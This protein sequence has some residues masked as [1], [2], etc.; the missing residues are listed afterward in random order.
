MVRMVP[1]RSTRAG[2]FVGPRVRLNASERRTQQAEQIVVTI[3]LAQ[4]RNGRASKVGIGCRPSVQPG[5]A[6]VGICLPLGELGAPAVSKAREAHIRTRRR[7][8]SALSHA[9]ERCNAQRRGGYDG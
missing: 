7:L 6:Q 1:V 4:A 3:D 5:K 8:E 9:N 2:T